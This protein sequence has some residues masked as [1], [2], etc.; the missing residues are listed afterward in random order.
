L[1]YLKI[2]IVVKQNTKYNTVV[3]LD[4]QL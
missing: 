2:A 3:K 1:T 4:N